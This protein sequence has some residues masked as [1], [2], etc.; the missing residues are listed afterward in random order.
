MCVCVC[1]WCGRADRKTDSPHN[2]TDA[3]RAK[4]PADVTILNKIQDGEDV[5]LFY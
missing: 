5:N 4:I 3:F 1:V 2:F